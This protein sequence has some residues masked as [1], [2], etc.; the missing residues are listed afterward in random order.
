M[1]GSPEIAAIL[2]THTGFARMSATGHIGRK[3]G[4]LA[5]LLPRSGEHIGLCPL[6]GGYWPDIRALQEV[7]ETAIVLPELG[8]RIGDMALYIDIAVRWRP[9]CA[10]YSIAISRS[11][12]RIAAIRNLLQPGREA[13]IR[14]ESFKQLA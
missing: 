5:E 1:P 7:S 12:E 3:S 2:G 11:S 8:C 4:V 13:R 14:I 10:R 9:D 6:L